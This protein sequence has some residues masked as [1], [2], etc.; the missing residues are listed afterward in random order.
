MIP[1]WNGKKYLEGCL[2]SLASQSFQDFKVIVVD[3]ASTDNSIE[4]IESK[5]PWVKTIK[6]T[7]NLGFAA[8]INQG[9]RT[10]NTEYIATLN[11]DTQCTREWLAS[12]LEALDSEP[13]AGMAAS[14]ML[15]FNGT[16]DSTGIEVYRSGG[17]YDRGAGKKNGEFPREVFGACAGAALYRRKMLEDIGLFDE[18]YFA[19]L[20]DVDLAFRARLRGWK[21]IYV[22]NA[23]V[24]HIHSA[25][26]KTG[27][28]KLYHILRNK[29]WNTWKYYPPRLILASMIIT[30]IQYLNYLT[31]LILKKGSPHPVEKY[32]LLDI[33]KAVPP[34]HLHALIALPRILR[35]RK[36]IQKQKTASIE[37]WL[38]PGYK[39]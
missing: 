25:T 9:I 20:E 33:L 34:S 30:T 28:F 14:R 36:K 5:F 18:S 13:D 7:R 29:L 32:Q 26:A 19:Y 11:N 16:I 1:N 24:Y 8:A 17:A 10:S 23:V 2:E 35:E 4:L 15:R 12:L 21:A 38:L 37:D 27:Y 6:N 31:R 3:N 22:P 39:L